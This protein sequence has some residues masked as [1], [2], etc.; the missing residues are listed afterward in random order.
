MKTI[1][2]KDLKD[3]QGYWCDDVDTNEFYKKTVKNG[4]HIWADGDLMSVWQ[5]KPNDNV[6]IKEDEMS[7][8]DLEK[9]LDAAQ[10]KRNAIFGDIE[11]LTYN[12]KK[13]D[14]EITAL[15]EQIAEQ[16]VTYSIGDRFTNLGGFEFMMIEFS[17]NIVTNVRLKTGAGL[18]AGTLSLTKTPLFR[19]GD[20]ERITVSEFA[21]L[22]RN[23][24]NA[25]R[26]WD[27][28]KQCK[29]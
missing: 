2:A 19:V 27:N 5:P 10:I 6:Y 1:K 14:A 9:Q 25:V 23:W 21:S 24:N 8:K 26:T 12:Q 22:S 13:A 11:S 7:K 4:R 28:R 18:S 15:K 20:V 16:E 29:C 3:G 17:K